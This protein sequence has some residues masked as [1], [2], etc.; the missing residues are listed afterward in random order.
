ML[1]I[2]NNDSKLHDYS[3]RLIQK[4]LQLCI[5]DEI[6][7]LEKRL[8]QISEQVE[9]AFGAASKREDQKAKE[10]FSGLIPK[11]RQQQLTD[12]KT[13]DE[14]DEDHDDYSC[15]NLS[16][17]VKNRLEVACTYYKDKI[18]VCHRQ[19]HICQVDECG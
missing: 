14:I 4:R 15:I 19:R 17:Y 16:Y 3:Y 18:P 8:L 11:L 13:N 10:M 2:T 6:S 12:L 1:N 9:K 5:A 7:G